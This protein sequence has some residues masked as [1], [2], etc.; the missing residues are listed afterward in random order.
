MEEVLLS[1]ESLREFKIAS[2]KATQDAYLK[3]KES[4]NNKLI[5]ISH[6]TTLVII[7]LLAVAKENK[8]AGLLLIV[9]LI[10]VF[11]SY[12]CF[13]FYDFHNANVNT[14]AMLQAYAEAYGVN[15]L[16]EKDIE[17]FREE[18]KNFI[19]YRT[20]YRYLIVF[21]FIFIVLAIISIYSILPVQIIIN[22]KGS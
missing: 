5:Q 20:S 18:Q 14:Y 6:I 22:C 17:F 11:S 1:N 7:A 12:I 4:E 3:Y 9:S 19:K 10:S 2:T 8:I 21:S 15:G 16:S 13:Y